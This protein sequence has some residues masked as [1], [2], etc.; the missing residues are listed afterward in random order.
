M[1]KS[2]LKTE[3]QSS[4]DDSLKNHAIIKYHEGIKS[5]RLYKS[6]LY[7]VD[8]EDKDAYKGELNLA[9]PEFND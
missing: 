6:E 1:I 9:K 4:C 5:Y 2:I 3:N 7:N 8:L